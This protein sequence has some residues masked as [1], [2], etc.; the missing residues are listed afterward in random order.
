M[1]TGIALQT[2]DQLNILAR[3]MDFSFILDPDMTVVP[4]NFVWD[5]IYHC[6]RPKQQYAFLGL[7]RNLSEG[8][9][10]ADGVNEKGLACAT[11]YF[12]NY[13]SY[14]ESPIDGKTNLA[15]YE[16]IQWMLSEFETVEQVKSA[17]KEI[18]IVKT[19]LDFVGTTPP[20]H[21]IVTD[22]TGK[23]IVIEPLKSGI[24]IHDNPLGILTNSPDFDWH[25]TN[26]RNYISLSP[27]QLQPVTFNGVTFAPF[28]QGSGTVGL[29]GDFTPPSRFIRTLF[30]KLAIQDFTG[31]DEGVNAAFHILSNVSI[32]KGSVVTKEKRNDYTQFVSCMCCETSTYYFRTYDNQVIS[33]LQLTKLDLDSSEIM[34]WSIKKETH[35]H[36]VI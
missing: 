14:Q 9:T 24:K 11:L 20:L 23:T 7:S 19:E 36:S 28:G 3:T 17:L 34:T 32:P 13:A 15:P 12:A 5:S 30:N 26:I 27:N 21:W 6:N 4:R 8:C 33:K 1:C 16:V 10:F 35:Y 31:E 29:P 18:C 22:K 2:T 25:M